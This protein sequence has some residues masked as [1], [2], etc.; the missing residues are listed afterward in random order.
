MKFKELVNKVKGY[1]VGS[2]ETVEEVYD[3]EYNSDEIDENEDYDYSDNYDDGDKNITFETYRQEGVRNMNANNSSVSM[4][5][6]LARPEEF[7]EV[8]KISDEI[9]NHKI[10]ILNLERVKSE[11]AKRILDFLSGASHALDATI[12]MMA[13]KTYAFMP[14]G[15]ECGGIDLLE[16]QANGLNNYGNYDL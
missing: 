3:P 13:S 6:V 5:M 4:K 1:F 9:K 15:V 14:Q 7:S 2:E 12:K 8:K 11:D 10:V 16:E